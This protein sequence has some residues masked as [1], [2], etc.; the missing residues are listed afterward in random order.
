MAAFAGLHLSKALLSFKGNQS[1]NLD[2]ARD[3]TDASQGFTNSGAIAGLVKTQ[4][5]PVSHIPQAFSGLLTG[6][7]ALNFYNRL[8]VSDTFID[9]GNVISEFKTP[10]SLWNAYFTPRELTQII[11]QDVEGIV[12]NGQAAPFSLLPLAEIIWELAA[13]ISGPPIIDGAFIF[14]ITGE[15]PLQLKL[16][17]QRIIAFAFAPNWQRGISESLEWKTEILSSE[18]GHEQRRALRET[19][20]RSISADFLIEGA[21]RRRF[22]TVLSEWG[23]RIWALPVWADALYL[24]GDLAAG[25]DSIPCQPQGFETLALLRQSSN[26][27]E[28]IEIEQIGLNSLNLKRPTVNGWPSG[29]QLLPV[30]RAF[31]T[32]SPAIKRKTDTLWQ[33]EADFLQNE[34]QPFIQSH[35]LPLHK[36]IP[37]LEVAPE[38]SEDLTLAFER[39]TKL[40]DNHTAPPL[41]ID[42]GKRAFFVQAHGFLSADRSERRALLSIFYALNG[43]QKPLWLPSFSD[44]MTLI[45]AVGAS[46]FQIDIER[47]D[48]AHFFKPRSI[49]IELTDGTIIYRAIQ[50]ATAINDTTERLGL[51]AMLGVGFSPPMVKRIS[52]LNLVR[53]DSDLITL[54]H[55]S[56]SIMRCKALFK[57]VRDGI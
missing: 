54:H 7:L 3:L 21:E 1:V 25:S 49:R 11:A 50:S 10:F 9:L 16:I 13:G 57:E 34:A 14:Q 27:F 41:L 28:V 44:D 12:L 23:A 35:T 42:H 55:L 8:W 31:L 5:A 53:Q 48:Y 19:P 15:A 20:R 51:S 33:I 45:D 43:K 38:E 2:T 26:H 30:R 46:A 24:E 40:L 52:W 37:V 4:G 32:K 36:N 17:G 29:T 47:I 18:Q 22:E 39:I 6:S 56:D